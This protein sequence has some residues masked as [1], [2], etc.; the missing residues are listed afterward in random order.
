MRKRT[1]SCFYLLTLLNLW[2]VIKFDD[3]TGISSPIGKLMIF[4]KYLRILL[5]MHEHVAKLIQLINNS[6]HL[7]GTRPIDQCKSNK[8]IWKSLADKWN[9]LISQKEKSPKSSG[10]TPEIVGEYPQRWR[11]HG[12]FG[13]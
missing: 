5:A 6:R 13:N 12:I 3:S 4:M 7:Q 1:Q 10:K 11:M 8:L 2:N 9:G